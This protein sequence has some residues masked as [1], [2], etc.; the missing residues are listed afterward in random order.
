M[1]EKSDAHLAAEAAALERHLDAVKPRLMRYPN[2]VDVYVGIKA[3]GGYGSDVVCF[4]AEVSDK[5]PAADLS[6]AERIP[7]QIDGVPVDVF[8][9]EKRVVPA[10][11]VYCGGVELQNGTLGCFAVASPANTKVAPGSPVMLTNHHVAS[12]IGEAVGVS[13]VCDCICSHCCEE[14]VIVDSRLDVS[15]DVAI[16][17][18]SSG[19]RYSHEILGIGP[20]RG[21]A[22]PTQGMRVSKYGNKTQLTHGQ[23]QSVVATPSP[24]GHAMTA[25]VRIIPLPPSP[26]VVQPG[27]SGSVVVQD[28]TSRVV[29]L[30]HSMPEGGTTAF[31][32]PIPAV[33]SAMNISIPV[34]GTADSI[35]LG[36][37]AAAAASVAGIRASV[38]A[39]EG[40]L[41]ESPLGRKWLELVRRHLDEVRELV[42]HDRRA[43]VAWQRVQG[44]AFV[45]HW[46]KSARE[47][48]YVVPAEI[49]G[50]RLENALLAMCAAL[51]ER[52][53][54]ELGRAATDHYL[55]LLELA[56][57]CRRAGD[58]VERVTAL[59]QGRS[60]PEASHG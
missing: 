59:A 25:Q 46:V 26:H 4:V 11:E 7:Q 14:G 28:A 50:M 34:M 6:P 2:V 58:F 35:P 20:V 57:G 5:R 42:N 60:G 18:L 36:A 27:D 43:K 32:S 44:P 38:A 56:R 31:A 15:V 29:G 23:I 17:K 55:T 41:E 47:P 45:S 30:I 3:V 40:K 37:V 54:P 48:D 51:R 16:A 21:S 52:G 49:G 1:P 9:R 39:L 8:E 22:P 12:K 10:S 53:S 24:G 19:T 33:L 13:S